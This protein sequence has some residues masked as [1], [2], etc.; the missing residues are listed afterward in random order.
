[1]ATVAVA[2]AQ[3]KPPLVGSA[4]RGSA[5]KRLP[6]DTFAATSLPSMEPIN[7]MPSAIVPPDQP[8]GTVLA[9][10]VQLVITSPPRRRIASRNNGFVNVMLCLILTY[11]LRPNKRLFTKGRLK[12]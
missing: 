9:V 12:G 6:S 10:P 2:G 11:S 3:P 8:L 4:F 7:R 1:M 5:H